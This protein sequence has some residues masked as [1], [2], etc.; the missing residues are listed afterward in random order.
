MIHLP[1]SPARRLLAAAVVTLSLAASSLSAATI[2]TSPVLGGGGPGNYTF[3]FFYCPGS[4]VAPASQYDVPVDV[5]NGT[6]TLN[7]ENNGVTDYAQGDRL[8]LNFT[9][10]TLYDLLGF[11]LSLS[12]ATFYLPSGIFPGTY[13]PTA[14]IGNPLLHPGYPSS[15]GNPD[16]AASALLGSPVTPGNTGAYYLSIDLPAVSAAY[17]VE[18]TAI[19]A[20][21]EPG[22]FGLAACGLAVAVAA[23]RRRAGRS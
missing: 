10:N 9:N 11:H 18:L 16:T 19:S 15:G 6:I 12:G 4:C 8:I 22:S 3:T 21:P 5:P 23:Y 1:L 2:P 14:F 7:L 17:T 20:V 13:S